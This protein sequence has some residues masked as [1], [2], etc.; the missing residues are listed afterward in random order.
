MDKIVIS[1]KRQFGRERHALIVADVAIVGVVAVQ[2]FSS[3]SEL[4]IS[5]AFTMMNLVNSRPIGCQP[6]ETFNKSAPAQALPN[7]DG[8]T[9]AILKPVPKSRRLR[10]LWQ[11]PSSG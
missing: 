5:A 11:W 1:E 7:E 2:R 9:A 4:S 10:G 6:I 3:S 8:K